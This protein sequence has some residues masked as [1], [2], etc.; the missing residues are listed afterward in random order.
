MKRLNL[1]PL[2]ENWRPPKLLARD[3]QL[4]VLLENRESQSPE[5]FWIQGNRGLGKTLTAT[6][7][8][9]MTEDTFIITCS[10]SSFRRAVEEFAL[11]NDVKP[12]VREDPSTII[13][14]VIEEKAEGDKITIFFDDID[15]LALGPT[16]TRDFGIHICNIYDRLLER[17]YTFSI[18]LIT[19]KDFKDARK[20]L[21]RSAESRLN[22]RPLIFP[23]YSEGEIKKLLMQRLEFIDD[24]EWSEEAVSYIAARVARDAEGREGD[25]RLALEIARAA[26]KTFGK[27]TLEAAEKAWKDRETDYWVEILK[28]MPF[29]KALLLASIVW[30][31]L[32]RYEDEIEELEEGEEYYPVSWSEV[33]KRW[34]SNAEAVGLGNVKDHRLRKWLDSLRESDLV[35]ARTLPKTHEYNYTNMR[36]LYIT[37]KADLMK[38]FYATQKIDWS[39]RW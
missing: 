28:E 5:N 8:K 1:Y 24:L 35:E 33:K 22:L 10:S 36:E 27:L 6:I 20:Y 34:R 30:E 39:K 18:H 2:S 16:L 37:L 12:K 29:G 13:L 17:G 32:D 19:T 25:M 3:K 15:R 23:P 14:R 26:I 21:D 31:T 9:E 11:K 7:F 38:L 4:K